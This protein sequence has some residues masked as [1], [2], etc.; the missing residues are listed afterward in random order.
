MADK[1]LSGL[2]P[3]H[4]DKSG[5]ELEAL[6]VRRY[7][8]AALHVGGDAAAVAGRPDFDRCL[9][10]LFA[11]RDVTED[12]LEL[13]MDAITNAAPTHSLRERMLQDMTMRGFG[14]HTFLGACCG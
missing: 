9:G 3:D 10:T 5:D 6:L 7:R 13:T 1:R 8:R 14:P 2:A 4:W 11:D 12:H